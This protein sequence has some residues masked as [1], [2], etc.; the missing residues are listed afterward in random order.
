MT[1]ALSH[2]TT[3]ADRRAFLDLPRAL[4]AGDDVWIEP[5][6]MEL[7]QR[8]SPTKNSFF[9]RADAAL[10]LA[11]RG[12]DVV[13]RISAQIDRQAHPGEHPEGNFG[14]YEA[15][16]DAAVAAALF[17]A[18]EEW[19]R[20]RG[21]KKIVGP[22]N[23]RL[24]DPAPGFL[25]HGF[26]HRPMFMSPYSKPYYVA[27]AVAAG[28]SEAMQLNA[29]AVHQDFVFPQWL[30]DLDA[31]ASRIPGLRVRCLEKSR[32]YQEAEIIRVI[33]NEALKDNWGFVPFSEKQVRAMA[34]DLGRICDPRI[35]LIAE[36]YGRPVGV[37]INLP[38]LNDLFY[39]CH[40]RLFPKGLYRVLF[41]KQDIHGLRGYALA[42]LNEYRGKGLGVHLIAESWRHGDVAGYTYGEI[43]WVLGNNTGMNELA[44]GFGGE[45]QKRYSVMEKMLD[46]EREK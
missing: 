10:F 35:I 16:D 34:R 4:Y 38:N 39:D 13:G 24:E 44:Q 2:V 23:F 43:T 22:Y 7:K 6:R 29:F 28:F 41:R 20:A 1:V 11:K 19:L 27:Q 36:V 17:G 25:I 15:V 8:L 33:F 14:F 3:A 40:G 12:R 21:V 18:A 30:K 46:Y 32:I 5:L 42:V 26:E 9:R 45:A 37:V 31:K